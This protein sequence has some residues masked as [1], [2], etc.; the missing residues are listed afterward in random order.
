MEIILPIIVAIIVNTAMGMIWYSPKLFGS[1]WASELGFNVDQLKASTKHFLGAIG[2]T[3]VT[4]L[5]TA[6]F[7]YVLGINTFID[8]IKFGFLVWLGFIA[9]NHFSG[10]IWAKKPLKIYFIDTSYLLIT[11]LLNTLILA[12]WQ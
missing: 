8:A 11:T 1:L 12:L 6:I 9:T 10:V 4:V 2:V 5:V 3:V 7:V